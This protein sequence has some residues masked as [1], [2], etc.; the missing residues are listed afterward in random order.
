MKKRVL[1]LFSILPLIIGYLFA[2]F[3][4]VLV[5]NTA[6]AFNLQN[7]AP[8]DMV[9]ISN[10]GDIYQLTTTN[11]KQI[12]HGQNLIEPVMAG[13]NIIAVA[14]TIN[15]AS[16]LLYDQSGNKIKTLFNGNTGTVD[17]MHWV[18]DPAVNPAQDR[19]AYVSDKDRQQTNVP[20]NALY[21]LNLSDGTSTNIANPDPYSGGIAH[22]VFNPVN[23]NVLLYD[24]YQYDSKTL[25]PYST[26][27]EYSKDTGFTTTLTFENKNAY[28]ESFSPDGKTLLFL[29]RNSDMNTVTL[30]RADFTDTGLMNVQTLASGDFA[31]PVFSNMK[32]RI[33]FLQSEENKGYNLMEAT[34]QK[35]K[36]NNIGPVISGYQLAGNSSFMVTK[37]K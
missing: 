29:G 6:P 10:G 17:T 18:T 34:M 1:L 13:G 33:Y 5:T 28:Q 16:L 2:S 32:N 21:V 12:I 36:L 7:I 22:P 19:I 23:G 14:K 26:I 3:H 24:Y 31:F 15:Y 4:A 20:D 8:G 37:M 35:G 11:S 25:A 30:Y 9:T 27:E